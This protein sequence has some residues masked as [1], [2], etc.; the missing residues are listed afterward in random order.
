MI[1]MPGTSYRGELAPADDALLSLADE[2]RQDIQQ[3]AVEIGER[4]LRNR[5][6]QLA[7][8]ADYI[9]AR[10][11]EAGYQAR[12]QEYEV[13]N[14]KCHNIEVEILGT[15][16]PQEIIIVGRITTPCRETRSFAVAICQTICLN[17]CSRWHASMPLIAM[18][19][20]RTMSRPSQ[21]SPQQASV[22]TSR[23]TASCLGQTACPRRFLERVEPRFQSRDMR[24]I[25]ARR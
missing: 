7:Q 25:S 6:Q 13:S 14:V 12:R 4:N 21:E 17:T 15:A 22:V 19:V 11:I 2:L 5:P 24:F 20:S 18:I 16:R 10:F 3:I 23:I 9:E 1:G 8:A